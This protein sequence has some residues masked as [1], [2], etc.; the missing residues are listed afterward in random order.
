[1]NKFEKSYEYFAVIEWKLME[2]KNL[3]E[4]IKGKVVVFGSS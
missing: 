2:L 1:M 3:Y 4:V